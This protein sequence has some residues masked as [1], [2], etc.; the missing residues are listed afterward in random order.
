MFY[1][2]VLGGLIMHALHAGNTILVEI[3]PF[4]QIRTLLV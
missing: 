1:D 3:N 2:Y 4:K